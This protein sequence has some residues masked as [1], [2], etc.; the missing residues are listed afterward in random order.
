M[1]LQLKPSDPVVIDRWFD[2]AYFFLW[3]LYGVW[4][5]FSLVVGLPTVHMAASDLY[6]SY[7]SGTIGI[8]GLTAAS[9][10][11]L[12]FF[13]TSWMSQLAKKRIERGAVIALISFIFVYPV[14]LIV[15]ASEGEVVLVGPSSVLT[16]S[17]LIFPV[18]RVWVLRGR[19][20]GIVK[21]VQ[22]AP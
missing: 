16:L 15:R 18:L 10:V 14:L 5:V 8:L 9:M 4:G 17:F 3:L 11:A 20:K 12:V 19:I 7:W 22:R 13:E 2:V 6:Q 1:K 21:A